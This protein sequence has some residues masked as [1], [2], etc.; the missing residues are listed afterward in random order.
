MVAVVGV[1]ILIQTTGFH[2]NFSFGDGMDGTPRNSTF[3]APRTLAGMKTTWENA[4]NIGS[5]HTWLEENGYAG[6]GADKNEKV[7]MILY[8]NCPGLSFLYEIPFA[9]K[10]AWP[11]L[12][13]YPYESFV[14]EL[15][16]LEGLHREK[17]EKILV[18]LRDQEPSSEQGY[19]KKEY[20]QEWMERNGYVCRYENEEYAVYLP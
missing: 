17:G 12:D 19:A 3:S 15:K 10:T 2:F 8:G 6:S 5:L 18:V 20:L 13:S 1:I 14:Q 4:E 16:E 7:Q 9:I 11:D